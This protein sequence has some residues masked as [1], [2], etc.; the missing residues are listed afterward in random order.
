MYNK[1]NYVFGE[2][3]Y[4][5]RFSVKKPLTVLVG[6]VI[7]LVL[8]VVAALK[9]TPDLMPNIDMPYVIV[10]TAYPGAT[11]EKVET[12]VTK[13]IEQSLATLENIKH[14]QSTSS[15]NVSMVMLE[16]NE[17]VNMDTV[18][19]DIL[20]KINLIEGG[21]DDMVASP[22]IL[23]LNPSMIP[24][25][26]AAVG[27][28]DMDVREL[29]DFV[30]SELMQQLEGIAGVASINASG[31]LE[32]SIRVELS[33][34]KLSALEN[35]ISAAVDAQFADAV[36]QIDV[37]QA[38]LNAGKAAL[39]AQINEIKANALMPDDMKSA[40][41]DQI[42]N[43]PE[44]A[45]LSEG[46]AQ[47]ES[48]RAELDAAMAKAH[49]SVNIS[50][51]VNADMISKLLTAQNF[52][53]PA[54]YA[55]KDGSSWIV[56]VGDAFDDISQLDSLVL[57]DAGIPGAESVKLSDVADISLADNA[58]S[59]YAKINGSNGI[60]LTFSKQS[61][62]AT[63]KVS[64]NIN[65]KFKALEKKYEGLHFTSLM[66]QGD[67]IYLIV[68]TVVENLLLGALF[69]VLILFLF[70]R[71]I[72]PTFII[73]CSI[74]ISVMFA[75]ALM[76]FTG[77]TLNM[78]SLSGLAVA[79]GMLVD[80]SV[81]V[82][83]NIYRLRAKG[84]SVIKAAVSGAAQVTGAIAAST[85]TTVCV[86]LPIVFVEGMTRQL[87]TD[88]ALTMAYA[89][90]ASLI[91]ALTLVPAMSSGLLKNFRERRHGFMDRFTGGYEKAIRWV[92]CHK[93][94]AFLFAVVMLAGSIVL[95]VRRGFEFMPD[96]GMPQLSATL[97]MPE[98]ATFE[99]TKETADIIS[100]KILALDEVD[101]VGA[102]MSGG[103][104]SGLTGGR[105]AANTVSL[106]VMLNENASRKSNE[107]SAVIND[108]F[109]GIDRGKVSSE[110]NAMTSM[111]Q[112][113]LGGRG[114][115]LNVFSD[116]LDEL[117]ESA[118]IIADRLS[119]LEGVAE[120]SDGIE[121]T[122]PALK[123]TVDKNKAAANGLT[124]AQIYMS[125]AEV[126]KTETTAT[127]ITAGGG[128]LDIIVADTASA[129][130]IEEL[131]SYSL[132]VAGMDGTERKIK[133]A[134]VAEI[135]ES[136]TMSSIKRTDQRRYLNVTASLAD[137]YN[138][139]L[140]TE[141][142]EE[143]LKK[144]ELPAGTGYEFKGE[145]ETIM[146]S[147]SD[148]MLMLGLGI[149]LVYLIM[150]AQFQ[151]LKSPFIVMFTI[152]LA[153]TGGF[154]GLLITGKVLSIVAMIGMI[155][156]TG[157]IVNNGIVL[158]D[159]INKLRED[160]MDKTEAIVEAGKTRMRPILMTTV[161]TVLGL[162]VMAFGR[163]TGSEMMQPI[164]IVCIGGLIYATILTLFIVPAMY[165][166]LNRKS[167]RKLSEEDLELSDE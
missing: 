95:T 124:V 94:I 41:I 58:D 147:M 43:S 33:S 166:I 80:N 25:T 31:I 50:S 23:K 109:A 30:R 167:I 116:D 66:D 98:D 4:M 155:M 157:I 91:I 138:V 32:Q 153:F 134:D 13:P 65:A 112:N 79:V 14:V 158:I 54:G 122:D 12:T 37:S 144:L 42:E 156:L 152:P 107:I 2:T 71:D 11:P 27:A 119:E 68:N 143:A 105:E 15:E 145:N 53:M 59:V 56:T 48:A 110:G 106:Y 39:D 52:Y 121:K 19:V 47:I 101:T 69:A 146:N 62:W 118:G 114:I 165:Y 51:M 6:V 137:G 81:V 96:M 150:V 16:F 139:S 22:I 70:L 73:L 103:L 84:M 76:Y 100:E 34:E 126:L 57:F 151:S 97:E 55:E 141:K 17:S 8:G 67:Y 61:S 29:S 72:K 20:Q 40:M 102:M 89:L 74:P 24:V 142:A 159:Y 75:I 162:A 10:M 140:V 117:A 3:A 64:N 123:I 1:E 160:G 129:P 9:M 77:V 5:S 45:Q 7:I 104:M 35:R 164:A 99:E 148:L 108:M 88:M 28:E 85:L 131:K 63:A 60:L 113:M 115:S 92:L 93:L 132:A 44:A 86:F 46:L 18:S 136:T 125:I 36:K 161:T 49:E 128:S 21:W 154:L 78:I 120:V 90:I 130:G 38:Q 87:F 133:L 163:G 149:L 26:V 82:I 135:A 111:M 83:E 127:S